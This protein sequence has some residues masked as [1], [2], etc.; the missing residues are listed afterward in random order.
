MLSRKNKTKYFKI[1]F[2]EIITQHADIKLTM[3]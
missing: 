1:V 3:F 2:N